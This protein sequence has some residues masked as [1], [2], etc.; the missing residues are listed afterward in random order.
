[1]PSYRIL[2]LLEFI[3][4]L[5][6]KEREEEKS[7]AMVAQ[8]VVYV[9]P[10]CRDQVDNRSGKQLPNSILL[11]EEVK[12]SC[13]LGMYGGTYL[14]ALRLVDDWEGDLDLRSVKI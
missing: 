2:P 9:L 14:L 8:F 13:S 3:M 5:K 6:E 10:R 12:S 7:V 1:M 4:S 11:S